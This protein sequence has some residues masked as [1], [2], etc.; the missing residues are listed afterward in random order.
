MQFLM[1]EL[2]FLLHKGGNTTCFQILGLKIK[3]S[4]ILWGNFRMMQKSCN[5]FRRGV[6]HITDLILPNSSPEVTGIAT[7]LI[8]HERTRICMYINIYIYMCTHIYMYNSYIPLL[9][10]N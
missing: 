1:N 6:S 8:Y 2:P 10:I 5:Y 4:T 9:R 7:T 3:S